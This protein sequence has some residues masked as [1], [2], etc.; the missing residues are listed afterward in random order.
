MRSL[1]LA[2]AVLLAGCSWYYLKPDENRLGL[3]AAAPAFSLPAGNRAGAPRMT[4]AEL[5]REGD[6]VV[7]FYRGHW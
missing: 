5:R 1:L 6:V 7:V 3:G 4:L 2:T